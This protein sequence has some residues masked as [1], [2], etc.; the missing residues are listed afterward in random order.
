M[1]YDY[2][3]ADDNMMIMTK[4][5]KPGSKLAETGY[6]LAIAVEGLR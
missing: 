2:D 1:I 5:I 6:T 4:L 3:D